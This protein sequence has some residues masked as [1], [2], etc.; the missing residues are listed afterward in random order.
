MEKKTDN[1]HLVEKIRLRFDTLAL[2][3]KDEILVLECFAG[4]GII[5]EHVRQFSNK[6]IRILRI[7][8]KP[9]KKGV[10]LKGD[11][12][13]FLNDMDLSMFDIIDLDA[14][15]SPYK[16]LEHVFKSTFR[17]YVHCTY[18]QVGMGMIDHGMLKSIGYT[19]SMIKKIPTLFSSNPIEKMKQYLS[20]R[21]ISSVTGYFFPRKNYFYFKINA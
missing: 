5:W 4:D 8:A 11:N 3:N 6:S 7:D 12:L 19:G 18:R 21:N 17:G 14:Y 20:V 1:S 15:G 2:I 16:Q 10:Y 13:K 9:D